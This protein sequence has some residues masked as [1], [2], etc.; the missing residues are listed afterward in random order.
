MSAKLVTLTLNPAVDISTSVDRIEAE[1][2]MRCGEAHRDP[3]GGGIN[4]ARVLSRTG[5]DVTALYP[6]GGVTGRILQELVARDGIE[7]I[8]IPLAGETRESFTAFERLTGNEFRFV[9]AGPELDKTAWTATRNALETMNG[10]LFVVA[11]G[12]LPP[13]APEEAYAEI[14]DI[15]RKLGARLAVDTSGAALAAALR[16]RPYLIKPNLRELRE[17][18]GLPIQTDKETLDAARR[19]VGEKR[20]D[21]VAVTLGADGA[22]LV[23]EEGSWRGRAPEITPVSSV[24][25][26]DSFLAMLIHAL[27][28][29]QSMSEALRAGMAGGTA[30]LL[31]PGTELCRMEDVERLLPQISI[32]E[33]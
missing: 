10:V 14:A 28:S 11:S 29:G 18:T 27:A 1:V 16:E 31:S 7:D 32:E 17:L 19:L 12:S 23:C 24:G 8:V 2:K 33:I 21:A 20:A 4:V 22:M 5:A 13:G 25:A 6:A 15:T 9:L 26:G 3:G 30:A